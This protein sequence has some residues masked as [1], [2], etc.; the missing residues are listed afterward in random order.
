MGRSNP[1]YRKDMAVAACPQVRGLVVLCS[2]LAV[3]ADRAV[4]LE[5]TDIELLRAQA[6][7]HAA[8]EAEES[9]SGASTASAVDGAIGTVAGAA[10]SARIARHR[11]QNHLLDVQVS[12]SGA[13]HL[14]ASNETATA[15]TSP[16]QTRPAPEAVAEKQLEQQEKTAVKS[17]LVKWSEAVMDPKKFLMEQNSTKVF[18]QG[19][20]IA[21]DLQSG[22]DKG[23]CLL[24]GKLANYGCTEICKC[25]SMLDECYVPTDG[26]GIAKQLAT[27]EGFNE[28]LAYLV[29]RCE[30]SLLKVGV[31]VA[32]GLVDLAILICVMRCICCRRKAHDDDD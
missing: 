26:W 7:K 21:V 22:A 11:I 20:K 24:T 17:S 8:H 31:L 3:F 16:N 6:G 23:M 25:R 4:K 13:L 1:I 10:E 9:S 18:I 19:L 27:T 29:G 12:D 32:F 30:R 14:K 2:L 5:D 28:A 15:P